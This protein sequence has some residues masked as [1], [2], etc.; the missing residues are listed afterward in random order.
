MKCDECPKFN[1]TW[2]TCKILG[3]KPEL[4]CPLKIQTSSEGE[5]KQ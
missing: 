3:D 2:K 5:T 4:P 1:K